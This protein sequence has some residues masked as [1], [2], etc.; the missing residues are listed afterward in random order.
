[1]A[2]T[3]TIPKGDITF[4]DGTKM[5][6]VEVRVFSNMGQVLVN[7]EVVKEMAVVSIYALSRNE[8]QIV[9]SDGTQWMVR[10]KRTCCGG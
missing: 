3:K 4:D 6:D 5:L 2:A 1:M 9:G 8:F 7:R 10:S